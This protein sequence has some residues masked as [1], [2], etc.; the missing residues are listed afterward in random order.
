MIPG[1]DNGMIIFKL[2]RER[3]ASCVH[4]GVLYFVKDRFLRKYTLG[5]GKDVAVIQL[6][7]SVYSIRER[8]R[9]R[10]GEREAESETYVQK[11]R[12]RLINSE[13]VRDR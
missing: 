7:Q 9:E 6:K 3:P 8:E 10:E 2:E 4:E 12:V 13:K 11:D 5:S 1:H